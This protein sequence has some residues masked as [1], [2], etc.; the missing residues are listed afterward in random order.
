MTTDDPDFCNFN[1]GTP[2]PAGERVEV[3]CEDKEG[4][5][6]EWRKECCYQN[7]R[8]PPIQAKVVGWRKKRWVRL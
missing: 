8:N 4:I 1:R 6:Y 2:P 3:L 5:N 7:K